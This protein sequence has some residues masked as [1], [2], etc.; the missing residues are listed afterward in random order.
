MWGG[1][2]FHVKSIISV[3]ALNCPGYTRHRVL[4]D[5]VE[6]EPA[7][8]KY[9][10][11][12]TCAHLWSIS[13]SHHMK[14]ISLECFHSKSSVAI[15]YSGIAVVGHA[16]GPYGM[17][18]ISISWWNFDN[19]MQYCMFLRTVT[20]IKILMIILRYGY[21]SVQE[22]VHIY[23]YIYIYIYVYI[24][25]YITPASACGLCMAYIIF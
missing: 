17:L 16:D 21:V 22:D 8:L 20:S 7:S 15:F 2:F 23:I 13:L 12:T 11:C 5:P 14:S 25:I 19:T 1:G 6:L 4:F 24:Y 18:S 10:P 3:L 9:Q